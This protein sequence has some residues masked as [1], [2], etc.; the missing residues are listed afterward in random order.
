MTLVSTL[1]RRLREV[2]Q[3]AL[4][5]DV[6]HCLKEHK[7]I[8]ELSVAERVLTS[9]RLQEVAATLDYD[10]IGDPRVESQYAA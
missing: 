6:E 5:S 10:M 8:V 2:S 7:D 9:I 4:F 3:R 1:E